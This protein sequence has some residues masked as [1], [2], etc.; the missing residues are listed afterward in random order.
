MENPQDAEFETS[1]DSEPHSS[2]HQTETE[3]RQAAVAELRR[4][5]P[6]LEAG[7]DDARRCFAVI[8]EN[9]HVAS[10]RLEAMLARK[11]ES[12]AP[13]E[14]EESVHEFLVAAIEVGRNIEPLIG[15]AREIE[16][17]TNEMA[18]GA[19]GLPKS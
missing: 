2:P 13:A 3:K 12:G 16:N 14:I 18:R 10:R 11:N 19:Q 1:P 7:C 15:Y 8:G 4:I 17:A 6:Q 5:L 9:F